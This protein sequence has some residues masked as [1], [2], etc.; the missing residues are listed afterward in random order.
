MKVVLASESQFRP[1]A[2]DLLG[3]VYQ[4]CPSGIGEKS[5]RDNNP[6]D[7]KRKL[8]EAKARIY[9]KPSSIGEASEFLTELSGSDFESR[10]TFGKRPTSGS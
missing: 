5:I 3:L 2:P 7:L 10:I 8:A 4:I 9:G 6:A 1:R